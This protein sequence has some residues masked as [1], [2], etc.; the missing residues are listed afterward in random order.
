MCY[1]HWPCVLRLGTAWGARHDFPVLYLSHLSIAKAAVGV[2]RDNQ[3]PTAHVPVSWVAR[4]WQDSPPIPIPIPPPP[5]PPPSPRARAVAPFRGM[6][7][8]AASEARAKA[9][10]THTRARLKRRVGVHCQRVAGSS[11]RSMV[12]PW[13]RPRS[14]P[15]RRGCTARAL[16]LG[17]RRA[18]RQRRLRIRAH[19]CD[20]CLN[21]LPP[22]LPRPPL[23]RVNHLRAAT[24]IPVGWL[25]E[26]QRYVFKRPR[27]QHIR[28]C[29]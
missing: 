14:P 10:P 15:R 27:P 16:R 21:G 18:G 2:R 17:A 26:Q 23:E 12:G 20:A 7:D 28:P 29:P 1:A 19:C 22:P 13:P 6:V 8:D 5:Q 9:Y 11:V 3:R 24:R 25:C 4:W